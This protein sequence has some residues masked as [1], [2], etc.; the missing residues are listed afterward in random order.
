MGAALTVAA[1]TLLGGCDEESQ[2]A[3]DGPASASAPGPAALVWR[4]LG[5]WSDRGNRQTESFDV[6]S[7][8]L[9]L[10]WSAED[11]DTS[12]P[13]H[14]AVTLHSAISGR[15]LESLLDQ[16]GTGSDTLRFTAS[17]RVAYLFVESQ[18]VAWHLTVE[19]GVP[20]R[21]EAAPSL[22]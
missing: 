19:E 17:P 10:V 18:G 12:D 15:P 3:L 21:R 13:D 8:A 20:V 7:G 4:E 22:P 11:D 5:S 9:R 2:Q 6:T 16:K 14:L 1:L